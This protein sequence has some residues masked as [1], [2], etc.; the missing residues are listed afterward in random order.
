MGASKWRCLE[1]NF[2][3]KSTNVFYHIES[4]HVEGAGYFCSICM[5]FC[6]TRNA[7][8]IH[9]SNYHKQLKQIKFT[10]STIQSC[11]DIEAEI[12]SKMENLGASKW[13]CIEC[14]FV[15]KS[16]NVYYHIEG[17]HVQGAG[18]FC[19]VCSK[20]CKTTNALNLHMSK[21]HKQARETVWTT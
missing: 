13:R 16:T 18:H 9:M 12:R 5:K 17:K 19:S 11:L 3:S 21:Y 14:N 15:S 10:Y 7:L 6:K 1:C 2:V 8:N 4:K 20:F